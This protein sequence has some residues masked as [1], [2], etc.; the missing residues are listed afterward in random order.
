MIKNNCHSGS[1]L[2]L[3]LKTRSEGMNPRDESRIV[4]CYSLER[5]N[6]ELNR[7]RIKSGM[8]TYSWQNPLY[9]EGNFSKI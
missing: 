7:F 9:T 4:V 1:S 6:P 2:G 5:G 3:V 8:T